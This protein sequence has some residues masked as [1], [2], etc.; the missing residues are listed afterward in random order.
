MAVFRF[1]LQPLLDLRERVERDRALVVAQLERERASI[2]SQ[3]REG[4]S[5]LEATRGDLREAVSGGVVSAGD[6]RLHASAAMGV[7]MRAHGLALRLAGV[8]RRL[9]EARSVLAEAAKER[10]AVE[11]L[12]ES[13]ER[14][15]RAAIAKREAAELDE[16]GT[17]RAGRHGAPGGERAS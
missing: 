10:R 4:Q 7:E 16:I 5:R 17:M 13:R 9:E 1:S 14:A 11:L 15:W 6:L 2:E 8:H 3:L 12:R